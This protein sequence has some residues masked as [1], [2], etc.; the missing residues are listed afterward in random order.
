MPAEQGG[1]G[2]HR[3]GFLTPCS[4]WLWC[5]HVY[6]PRG[7]PGGSR[8]VGKPKVPGKAGG[9][10][11]GLWLAGWTW[12][13]AGHRR[14]QHIVCSWLNFWKMYTNMCLFTAVREMEKPSWA[15]WLAEML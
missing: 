9:S 4:A 2:A 1:V 11:V 14:A 12:Q 3:A 6:F 8:R 7:L 13:V 15:A 5:R 10:T